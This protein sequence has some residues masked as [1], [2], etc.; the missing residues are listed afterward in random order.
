MRNAAL[1][2]TLIVLGVIGVV[3]YFG[4][5]PDKDVITAL[6]FVAAGVLILAMDGV[7]KSS[8]VLGPTLIAIGIMWWLHDQYRLRWSLLVPILLI[9]IGALMLVARRPEIPERRSGRDG[10]DA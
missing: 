3:V 1:P 8:V 7:T 2:V 4:W 6:G 9:L 10:G 5:L